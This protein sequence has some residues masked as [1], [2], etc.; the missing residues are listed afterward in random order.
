[1]TLF[2][3]ARNLRHRLLILVL[4]P[5]LLLLIVVGL[6]VKGWSDEVG[7][8]QLLMKVNTD[9]AVARERF[10]TMQQQYQLQ[11]ALATESHPT[12][13][14]LTLLQHSPV[15]ST[16]QNF[17]R[18][19]I[20]L[21]A[22]AE[23]DY[24]TVLDQQGCYLLQPGR[25]DFP[26]SSLLETA[27]AGRTGS[28]LQVL[29]ADA[30]EKLKPGLAAQ[31]RIPLT[32][33]PDSPQYESR[34]MM[35]Q[36]SYP[37]RDEHGQVD[38]VLIGGLLMNGNFAFVDRLRD[39]V[40]GEGSL[41]E[42]SLGTVTLFLDDVRIS[43]NVPATQPDGQRAL[44]TRVSDQV[45]Q[46][47]LTD[48]RSWLNRAFVVSDWYISGYQPLQD[49]QGRRIGMLYT[50][51]LEAPFKAEFYQ[52][53]NW[54]AVLFVVAIIGCAFWAVAG[55]RRI[56][57]PVEKMVAVIGRI[58]GGQRLRMATTQH[59]DELATLAIAFNRMLER[60]EQQHD[61]I[62]QAAD[63]LELKVAERTTDLKAHIQLLQRT[64]EQLVAKGKLA[65]IGEL[66]AGIAH[67]INNPTAV[68]LGYLDLMMSE[69]GEAGR[70]VAEEAQLI[71]EQVERIRTIIN[72]LLQYSRP[73]SRQ[74]PLSAVDINQLIND[75]MALTRHDMNRKQLR[76]QL[77]LRASRPVYSHRSQLQQVLINLLVNAVNASEQGRL[78]TVRSRNRDNGQVLLAIRD[79]GCGMDRAMQQR[80]F[81]P[82]FSQTRGGTGLGL[83]VSY[84]LLQ[85]LGAEIQ[86]RSRAGVGSVFFVW[87]PSEPVYSPMAVIESE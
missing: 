63:Q 82:F 52:W 44:G 55:A 13:Q 47:V 11:L 75:T 67:E 9:I 84:A 70:P 43:T 27:L 78:I 69:L 24:V 6:M 49:L 12:R 79:E 28:G 2:S 60:L 18:L 10:Q 87:L 25:C 34:G 32:D 3:R 73:D 74:V 41:L 16:T 57:K 68:I 59:D 53:L 20:K 45:R 56:F 83:S 64:R 37:L 35:L 26:T 58:Q 71:V 31:A 51:F 85:Q 36:L 72:N 76:L 38:A 42:G 54:L 14:Y 40:Y 80:I 5:L 81:D 4:L 7:Y 23:L 29:D 21:S 15:S 86:V 1:M 17:E 62:A 30:L 66:T 8:R 46:H 39:T 22:I 33:R 77:D 19:L 50:G 61:Q 65:A 48:G